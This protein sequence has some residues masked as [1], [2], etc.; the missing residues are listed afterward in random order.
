MNTN[1]CEYI[2]KIWI[3]SY[4]KYTG[5][6]FEIPFEFW[7]QKINNAP[8]VQQTP[9]SYDGI[10]LGDVVFQSLGLLQRVAACCGV[11]QCVACSDTCLLRWHSLVRH[12]LSLARSAE[13]CSVLQYVAACCG[14]L[15]CVAVTPT[16]YNGIL[17][18]VIVF[19]LLG[20]AV[21]PPSTLSLTLSPSLP[22]ALCLSSLCLFS[23][24]PSLSLP[25]PLSLCLSL[26]LT[27]ILC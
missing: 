16:S 8:C 26:S 2:G 19:Q 3:W 21:S 13:W 4:C 10:L 17:L 25:L 27:R 11:L 24:S 20:L 22:R 1:K 5:H 23:L 12:C 18:G 6:L 9:A 15:Q 14:V 7:W